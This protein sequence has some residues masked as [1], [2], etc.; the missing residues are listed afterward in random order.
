M[1]NAGLPGTGLGGLFYLLL[2]FWMPFAELPRTL[3]GRS[4]RARWRAGR[5]A[6]RARLRHRRGGG[7]HHGGLP[8]RRRPAQ[9]A[10]AC[11]DPRSSWLRWCSRRCLLSWPGRGAADV[12]RVGAVPNGGLTLAVPVRAS[13]SST[14]AHLGRQQPAQPTQRTVPRHPDRSG[15]HAECRCGGCHVKADDVD[16]RDHLGLPR[17]Q[18]L[19][20]LPGRVQVVDVR[21]VGRRL[22]PRGLWRTSWTETGSVRRRS[23]VRR[24]LEAWLR[25]IVNSQAG[26]SSSEP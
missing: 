6:V 7:R 25:A 24:L 8:E 1:N 15:L 17:G 10:S 21:E 16:A 2:A 26:K 22:A 12:G 11:A 18:V 23:A 13:G 4:S 20:Q 3:R 14:P 9:P 19:E 5:D